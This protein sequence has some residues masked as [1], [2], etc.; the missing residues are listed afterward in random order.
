MSNLTRR[1][2]ELERKSAVKRGL[3]IAMQDLEHPDQF[4]SSRGKTYTDAEL[5]TLA[6]QGWQVIRVVYE[7]KWERQS[8]IDS[9][10]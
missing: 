1:I 8:E 2:D 7:D 10:H 9:A 6:A 5:K 3:L 4:T